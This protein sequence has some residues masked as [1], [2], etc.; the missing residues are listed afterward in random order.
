MHRYRPADRPVDRPADHRSG[1]GRLKVCERSRRCVYFLPTPPQ[2]GIRRAVLWT[3]TK[4][5]LARGSRGSQLVCRSSSRSRA[6][7]C[8]GRLSWPRLGDHAPQVSVRILCGGCFGSIRPT[9]ARCSG[10]YLSSAVPPQYMVVGR[11]S[12]ILRWCRDTPIRHGFDR[13]L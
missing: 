5:A 11:G 9:G 12:R 13:N 7:C 10:R 6:S 8:S 2:S 1:C 4:V 3:P